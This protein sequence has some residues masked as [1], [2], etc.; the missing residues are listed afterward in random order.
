MKRGDIVYYVSS[1]EFPH[2]TL[3]QKL[4]V[5]SII[6]DKSLNCRVLE[7]ADSYGHLVDYNK[8]NKVGAES[9][10]PPETVYED[11]DINKTNVIKNIFSRGKE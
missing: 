9:V 5:I 1:K 7:I 11:R 10:F 6:G 4:K 8:Y 2:R 3:I